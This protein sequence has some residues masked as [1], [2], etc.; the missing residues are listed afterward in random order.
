M[1]KF[2]STPQKKLVGMLI[3]FVFIPL[4]LLW[5]LIFFLDN[6]PGYDTLIV[7]GCLALLIAYLY[8]KYRKQ[9]KALAGEPVEEDD[10]IPEKISEDDLEEELEEEELEEDLEELPE[11]EIADDLEEEDFK[12]E[13]PEEA[14]KRKNLK[15]S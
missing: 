5:Y 15:K 14:P 10:G 1:G 12:E 11:E 4:F 8:W 6:I 7:L 3:L 13:L 9:I 2:K